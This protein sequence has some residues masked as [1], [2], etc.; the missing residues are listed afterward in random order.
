MLFICVIIVR[1]STMLNCTQMCYL[2]VEN[3]KICTHTYF[4]CIPVYLYHF[5]S[6]TIHYSAIW[7]DKIAVKMVKNVTIV[8]FVKFSIIMWIHILSVKTLYK[9]LTDD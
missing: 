5:K 3:G 2:R 9:S 7:H 6:K 1:A 4:F 8:Y